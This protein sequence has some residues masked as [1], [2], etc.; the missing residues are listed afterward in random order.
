MRWPPPP[1]RSRAGSSAVRSR[2]RFATF[3]GVPHRLEEVAEVGGVLYVNDSKATNVASAS[4]GIEAFDGG[5]HAILGGSLKGG[6]FEGLREAAGGTLPRRLPDRRGGRGD[7]GRP[8]WRGCGAP[9]RRSG[10][11]ARWKRAP[12]RNRA[13]SSCYHPACASF[14]QYR[15]L[16]GAGGPL[17][18]ARRGAGLALENQRMIFRRDVEGGPRPPRPPCPI[19]RAYA[20]GPARRRRSSTRSSTRPRSACSRAVP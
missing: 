11:R 8:G 4:V 13:T 3:A 15:G 14:D 1:R 9:L 16:R 5:V 17:P 7:R 6:G 10:E 2:P 20:R 19:S 18:H 12:R